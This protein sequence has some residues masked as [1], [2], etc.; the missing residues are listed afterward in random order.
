MKCHG[1]GSEDHLIKDCKVKRSGPPASGASSSHRTPTGPQVSG[2]MGRAYNMSDAP[3]TQEIPY[4]AFGYL[5][6]DTGRKPIDTPP[7][8]VT[9]HPH[10]HHMTH[11]QYHG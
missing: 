5:A 1:C 2:Q 3:P 9:S 10:Q 8:V 4:F 7:P 6:E 11:S